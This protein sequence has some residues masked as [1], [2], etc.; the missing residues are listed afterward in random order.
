MLHQQQLS[1]GFVLAFLF[2]WSP[3]T[4]RCYVIHAFILFFPSHFL[5]V[6]FKARQ[7]QTLPNCHLYLG[8]KK[9]QQ[10]KNPVKR[11]Q[12]VSP[13]TPFKSLVP[14][15]ILQAYPAVEP[16]PCFVGLKEVPAPSGCQSPDQSMRLGL[17]LPCN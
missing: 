1:V 11:Y 13:R 16:R 5:Q 6:H 17:V 10:D 7:D 4:W 15:F 12:G 2:S 14:S 8:G 3:P 9:T